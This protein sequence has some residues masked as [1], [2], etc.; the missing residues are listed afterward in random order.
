MNSITKNRQSNEQINRMVQKAFS[1]ALAISTKEFNDGCFNTAYGIELSDGREV[2][3]KIAPPTGTAVMSYEKNLMRAETGSMRLVSEKTDIP[4]P[5]LL[6]TDS[7]HEICDSDYF[8]MSKL[9]GENY[10]LIFDKI[11]EE[12]RK[13]IDF[14]IG[15]YNQKI[16]S[17]VGEKFGYF[18]LPEKQGT[19]WFTVFY[20][21]I[22]LLI[23]DAERVQVDLPVKK[24]TILALLNKDK[25]IF[26]EVT[27][28]KLIHW[29]I[30]NGNVFVEGNKVTG[31]IDFERCLWGDELLEVGFRS[32]LYN[33]NFF[34]GY[35][36]SKLSE[37]QKRR[38]RWYDFYMFLIMVMEGEYRKYDD[39]GF[40]DWGTRMLKEWMAEMEIEVN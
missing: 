2:I 27:I 13:K 19:H 20:S 17:I 6:Y 22:E 16:N 40:K 23:F 9:S 5:E 7:S 11:S 12:D 38:A 3:L 30:W 25:M 35:G 1:G 15:D 8:F 14:Q 18:A 29:D 33:E 4:I 39:S 28:P 31:L 10:H 32:Y 21:M 37:D 36:I 26:D 24:E 34:N